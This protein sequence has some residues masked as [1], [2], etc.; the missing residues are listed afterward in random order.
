MI[1]ILVV[2]DDKLVRKGLISSMPW[3]N[4]GMKVVGE[5][6]NGKKALE[7]LE[8]HTDVQLLLTDLSMP[9]MSGLELIREV[10]KRYPSLF[11]VVLTIHQDFEYIQ[12]VLRLGSIDYI[13][14]V[15]LETES[16]D[17]VLER[18]YLRIMEEKKKNVI[19]TMKETEVTTTSTNCFAIISLNYQPEL[20]KD[21]SK[22]LQHLHYQ[23][24]DNSVWICFDEM[25]VKQVVGKLSEDWILIKFE[26]I[27]G[28]NVN[29][30]YR[31]LRRYRYGNLFYDLSYYERY[32]IKNMA[33]LER[34]SIKKINEEVNVQ[35]EKWLLFKWIFNEDIFQKLKIDLKHLY[36]EVSKLH[37]FIYEIIVRLNEIYNTIYSYEFESLPETITTWQGVEEWL[38]KVRKAAQ[39]TSKSSLNHQYS[40]EI[41]NGIMEA[42]VIIH[43]EIAQ[44]VYAVDVA[45]RVNMSRSYFNQCFKDIVGKSF[46]EYLRF[47]RLE[48]SKDYLAQTNRSIQMIAEIVGYK[49]EKYYSRL[50]KEL[51]GILPSEYRK[52]NH[53]H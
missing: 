33:D 39:Q 37:Q 40:Q 10:R 21:I 22:L 45:K 4:F 48:K 14:K 49:D 18:I 51:Y 34:T 43:E 30:I 52:S 3:E 13:S 35:K 7:F 17:E 32:M 1:N 2:D 31:M 19:P 24:I 23:E 12:E 42:V 53:L 8:E 25:N 41:Y 15:Q 9:V 26:G 28:M 29:Q 38:E 46:N 36:L 44:Q 20:P 16:F 6:S 47:V 5:A 27:Y 11:I 50:F